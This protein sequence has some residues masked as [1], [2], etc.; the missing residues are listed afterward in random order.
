MEIPAQP[1]AE[2]PSKDGSGHKPTG[3]TPTP[4]PKKAAENTSVAAK[5]IL[6]KYMRR[7]RG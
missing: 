4:P 6:E 7:P 1:T 5:A 3:K 2:E